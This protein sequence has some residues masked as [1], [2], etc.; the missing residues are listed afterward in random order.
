MTRRKR[1]ASPTL[2]NPKVQKRRAVEFSQPSKSSSVFAISD[3]FA[4]LA[5]QC[6]ELRL[7]A[8]QM[9]SDLRT[10]QTQGQRLEQGNGSSRKNNDG[11]GAISDTPR[12]VAPSVN[13]TAVNRHGLEVAVGEKEIDTTEPRKRSSNKPKKAKSAVTYSNA[14]KSETGTQ[15]ST[16]AWRSPSSLRLSQRRNDIALRHS[17]IDK[18]SAAGNK[19]QLLCVPA[20]SLVK[21]NSEDSERSEP[22]ENNEP[23]GVSDGAPTLQ[24]CKD[25]STIVFNPNPFARKP[26][27]PHHP[28]GAIG[29]PIAQNLASETPN[30]QPQVESQPYSTSQLHT[31]SR[32][33]DRLKT[34]ERSP[35]PSQDLLTQLQASVPN[36]TMP[37][38]MVLPMP[39]QHYISRTQ[40]PPLLQPLDP[41]GNGTSNQIPNVTDP[42]SSIMQSHAFQQN[43]REE[44][45]PPLIFPTN[46]TQQPIPDALT[47]H[48]FQRGIDAAAFMASAPPTGYHKIRLKHWDMLPMAPV[49]A[50]TD[51]SLSHPCQPSTDYNNSHLSAPRTKVAIPRQGQGST[52]LP[53]TTDGGLLVSDAEAWKLV[54]GREVPSS[55]GVGVD[56]ND[57]GGFGGIGMGGLLSSKFRNLTQ[58]GFG[59]YSV[60]G[61]LVR[62]NDAKGRGGGS[63]KM[64]R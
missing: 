48:H 2:P 64:G 49:S 56:V 3:S 20:N 15:K 10:L 53:A 32:P 9:A 38:P 4:S 52:P 59:R 40:L 17:I 43:L 23:L 8:S 18:N 50:T 29:Q 12:K 19:L 24:F 35:T 47:T 41:F 21:P 26:D 63:G 31:D 51:Y 60:G 30:T 25:S 22:G 45:P 16:Q 61:R 5:A 34:P 46:H 27:F 14:S 36:S 39:H 7:Q 57:N 42:N 6:R 58:D 28:Q 54:D 55:I 33:K 44:R 13:D 37:G 62:Q 1:T 11:Y